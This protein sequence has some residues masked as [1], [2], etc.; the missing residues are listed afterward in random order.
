M[1][2]LIIFSEPKYPLGQPETSS[3][4]STSNQTNMGKNL[5]INQ[6][7][8]A[9]DQPLSTAA[10]RRDLIM[11]RQIS[12]LE[13]L[14]GST[15]QK[16]LQ[17]ERIMPSYF[18]LLESY[19]SEPAYQPQS[20]SSSSRVLKIRNFDKNLLESYEN[21]FHYFSTTKLILVS[22]QCECVKLYPILKKTLTIH[23]SHELFE[24]ALNRFEDLI[25]RATEC[26]DP[27]E[28][29]V[30]LSGV[31]NNYKFCNLKPAWNEFNACTSMLME[32]IKKMEVLLVQI[33]TYSAKTNPVKVGNDHNVDK[34]PQKSSK[35]PILFN[36][37]KDTFMNVDQH[38]EEII[39][40]TLN[41]GSTPQSQ[42]ISFTFSD[43]K[44]KGEYFSFFST[45]PS[46]GS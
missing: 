25:T 23:D 34:P 12:E 6:P 3:A 26:Y 15:L 45:L 38:I 41:E 40:S 39:S 1:N 30:H 32:H 2:Y 35:N 21:F 9:Y 29:L 42:N 28:D 10:T 27:D 37:E 44:L 7:S 16:I 13:Q 43:E 11:L 36:T 5:S 17:L 14:I 33:K 31:Q 8:S 24:E 18:T 4:V 19:L 20:S 22:V 46:C